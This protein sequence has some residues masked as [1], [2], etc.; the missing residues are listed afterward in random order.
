MSARTTAWIVSSALLIACGE[1][2]ATRAPL[3]APSTVDL[4]GVEG[5]VDGTIEGQPFHAIDARF[6]VVTYEGR[7]RVD[8]LFADQAIELCGLPLA[9]TQSRVWLRIPGLTS[10]VPGELSLL[11]ESTEGT[12]LQVH[13]ERP[14]G[15]QFT[16]EHR[17]VA[18]VEITRATSEQIDGRVHACF[19][20][21]SQSCIAGSFR[22][23]PCRGRVDGRAIR[24]PPGIADDALEPPQRAA[25]AA[26]EP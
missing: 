15:R 12:P 8:L 17:G 19:A 13:Y 26:S 25:H 11:D 2:P 16:E 4:A 18:R 22:A 1:P 9:R 24:E 10:L 3:P 7:E 23:L 6:R 5:D 21:A 14:N 20:D